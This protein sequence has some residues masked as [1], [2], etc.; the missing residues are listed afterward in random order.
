M[1]YEDPTTG[2]H[3]P[4]RESSL[5]RRRRM[6]GERRGGAANTHEEGKCLIPHSKLVGTADT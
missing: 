4:E 3:P 1:I 6:G 5:E 2:F